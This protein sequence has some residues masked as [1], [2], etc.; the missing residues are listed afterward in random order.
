[1]NETP[2]A[3]NSTVDT[4]RQ[5]LI[6]AGAVVAAPLVVA[7]NALAA[8][9]SAQTDKPG[10]KPS[11]TAPYNILFVFTD[12]ERYIDKWP[13]GLALPGHERLKRTGVT[14]RITTARR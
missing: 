7:T 4:R 9:P 3:P 2:H 5:F 11:R 14:F 12:Q 1:M 10:T 13:A 8:G 6:K